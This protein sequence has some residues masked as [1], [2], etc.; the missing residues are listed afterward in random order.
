[1]FGLNNLQTGNDPATDLRG[2]GMLGLL[3]LLYM[4]SDPRLIP[5]TRDIYRLSR[6]DEQV[7]LVLYLTMFAINPI[8]N[9]VVCAVHFVQRNCTI[10]KTSTDLHNCMD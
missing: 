1:M 3:Q 6:H 9:N 7:C 10:A 4:V 2:S 5:L 8:I